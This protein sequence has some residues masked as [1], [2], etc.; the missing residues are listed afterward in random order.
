MKNILLATALVCFLGMSA[1]ADD[2]ESAFEWNTVRSG[3][4][5]LEMV[6]PLLTS[7]QQLNNGEVY[8]GDAD[9]D[10]ILVGISAET[11]IQ[12]AQRHYP[13]LYLVSFPSEVSVE[14][15]IAQLKSWQ[16]TKNAWP[17]VLVPWD[18]LKFNPDDMLIPG[19]WHIEAIQ[20]PAAWAIH[21]GSS[22]V[23]VAIIDGGVNYLHP[24]LSANI[25]MNSGEDLNNN[26][27]I[28]PSEIDSIDN[29]GNG[30]IDD[31]WGWDWIDLDSSAVW[32]GEDPGPP[33]NDPS[34][35][36]G[37]G[38]H[39][40]GDA[41]A[42]TNNGI[43]VASPGFD[44][45][46]MALR[47]GY[48]SS[49]G[50][51]YVDLYAAMQAV[52]YAVDMDAEVL[53]MSF[54]GPGVVPYFSATLEM[55][56]NYGLIPIAAAGNDASSSIQYPAGYDFVIA[57]AATAP[58][59]VLADFTNY[60]TWIT[61]CAPGDGIKSTLIE[62][63]GSM[64]G[65]SMATPVT[66]G[67]AASVKSLKPEW[68]IADVSS[69]LYWTADNIDTQN[70]G[71][72]GMMG[73]GRLNAAKAVD[74]FVTIDSIWVDNGQGGDRLL[75][76]QDG[77]LFVQYHKFFDTANN[78]NI[79]VSSSNPAVSFT[80]SNHYAGNLIQ[81]QV[82]DN[83]AEPFVINVQQGD[84]D[85]EIIEVEAQ[86]TG[87]S[88]NYSQILQ[89]PVGRAQ[90]LIIDAD[91]NNEENTSIYYEDALDQIGY[92]SETWKR[93]DREI[94]GTELMEYEAVIHFSGTAETNIFPA[95]DWDDL[96]EYL[97]SG[98]KM[99]VTGQN[100]AEDLSVSQPSIL[101]NIFRVS[102]LAPHA[103][104]LTVRGIEGNPLTEDLYFVMAGSGGAWNQYSMDVITALP[105][106]S[107]PTFIYRQ[108]NPDELA[109][110]RV[111]TAV[112]DL[113][114]CCFGIEGINDSTSSGNTRY[115]LLSMMFEE[116]GIIPVEMPDENQ[117][118]S[119]M[120][121]HLPYPNP[122]NSQLRIA[123]D[124]PQSAPVEI[125][126]FNIQGERIA[127]MHQNRAPAGRSFWTWQADNQISSGIYI[128]NLT[129]SGL[130]LSRKAV[131][132]K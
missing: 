29:D 116:F 118:P 91:Q 71:Y 35:F 73:G 68:G 54:G 107:E 103:E 2:I 8:T 26:R 96:D 9:L 79:T 7:P 17:S 66:A 114:Y 106:G 10:A 55:A 52:Y 119:K 76:N 58:G 88:F 89:I 46:I 57:V 93:N 125:E 65:T 25:W 23:Q 69:W 40:A 64:S 1:V 130:T 72:V 100:V 42:V 36:D 85:F 39:C 95:G 109:G 22:D 33:D 37:H 87:D 67:V 62:G 82:G 78:V 56:S 124:L 84:D 86:I 11:L 61:V 34:D 129:S 128:I 51:G 83:S 80:Q 127:A 90:I 102:Y 21:R 53:S 105:V 98:G 32:P 43:G 111:Q 113:F 120:A 94:L 18:E 49:S 75:F 3:K 101:T 74:L 122:F 63:Y 123:Y 104:I 47:A 20:T 131:Y 92:T 97:D 50:M 30:Y 117:I 27:F 59:D 45:Q 108:E 38:T 16:G 13:E 41:C 112:S 31:F 44:C 60:G 70:P 110:V 15:A 4:V 19:Q 121:L 48:L 132:L 115:D 81:G 6:Q 5:V 99:I 126:I 14:D 28:E 24:D 12:S 77:S